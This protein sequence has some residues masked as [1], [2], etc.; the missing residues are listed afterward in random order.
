MFKLELLRTP[1]IR[2]K[3]D[4]KEKMTSMLVA[5]HYFEGLLFLFLNF[6]KSLER[7]ILETFCFD[8]NTF[9]R[10]HPDRA[11]RSW[12]DRR[13]RSRGYDQAACETG[14]I[15][16]ACFVAH[17]SNR[18]FTFHGRFRPWKA[19]PRH[20]L[21]KPSLVQ[22]LLVWNSGERWQL[23]ARKRAYFCAD[24]A[25]SRNFSQGTRIQVSLSLVDA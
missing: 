13:C 6:Q 11:P 22:I 25:S 20:F 14:K 17:S 21:E 10:S 12:R 16:W 18:R 3:T 9:W 15:V 7:R 5:N 24:E 19:L 4:R 23:Q 2:K 1:K 8:L